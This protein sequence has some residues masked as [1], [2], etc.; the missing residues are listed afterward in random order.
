MLLTHPCSAPGASL[1]GPYK[2]WIPQTDSR[3]SESETDAPKSSSHR[4]RGHSGPSSHVAG[5]DTSYAAPSAPY[6]RYAN[7]P[8]SQNHAPM[9]QPHRSE[10][11]LYGYSSESTVHAPPPPAKPSSSAFSIFKPQVKDYKPNPSNASKREDLP[12]STTAPAPV[13]SRYASQSLPIPQARP[14]HDGQVGVPGGVFGS[15]STQTSTDTSPRSSTD[16]GPRS[17]HASA[18]A[19]QPSELRKH[20][21]AIWNPYADTKS[22]GDSTTRHSEVATSSYKRGDKRDSDKEEMVTRVTEA[23]G[24]GS[25]GKAKVV[26]NAILH[27]HLL[28]VKGDDGGFARRTTLST[29]S[30]EVGLSVIP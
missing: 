17:G 28:P 2:R 4:P 19:A 24:G 22:S 8:S 3:L 30:R 10:R 16:S 11:N 26:E 25:T 6:S 1:R 12:R 9:S 27:D 20:G 14:S 7:G 23:L 18:P 13:S 21:H 15:F 29:A 5:A